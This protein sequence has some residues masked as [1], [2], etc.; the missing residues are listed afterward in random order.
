MNNTLKYNIWVI[1][2]TLWYTICF[3]APYF[4][5][6]PAEGLKGIAAVIVYICACGLGT[7]FLLYLIGINRYINA[8]LLPLLSF[9]GAT[10]SFYRIG[11][12][13]TLTPM[14]IDV[15]LH[16]NMEEAIGVTSW[17]VVVW[18]VVNILIACAFVIIRWKKITL[19]YSWLHALCALTLGLI[20]FFCN[21]RLQESLCQRFPYNIPYNIH[22]YV[23]LQQSYRANR[24]IPEFEM[25]EDNDSISIVLIIGEAARADHI[26]INGYERETT[27]RLKARKN[28]I[29]FPYIHCDQTHTLASLPYILTRADSANAD[30]QYSETSFISVFKEC[31]YHTSWISNQ[32]LGST[33][34]M[35]LNECDTSVFVNADKTVYVF[36]QWLDEEL[37][38][39]MAEVKDKGSD[40]SLIILH[41]IGSHWYYNNHVRED[42]KIFLPTTVNK[43]VTANS[44]E[45]FVNSY[46]N[47]I[48]YMDFFIDS[49]ISTLENR[50]SIIIYQS[51]HGEALGEDGYFLHANGSEFVKNPACFIWYSD[52]YAAT[53]PDKIKALIANKDKRYRTDYVFYSI[54]YAAG[55]EAEGD[56]ADVNIFR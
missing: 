27:P 17:Q 2:V 52:K 4:H 16:T 35:Y 37:I 7:Y 12:S 41:T 33:F 30:Y 21:D 39:V 25:L 32:D 56:N 46:D 15:I 14:L 50:N 51:D 47:T 9:L 36:S 20:C 45:Q 10:L 49:V 6:I 24:R 13:A 18:D 8:A 3:I 31:G 48:Y 54:L 22:E 43:V 40:K 26:Q 11:Y 42:M 34:S 44:T 28:I 5:D 53:H 1:A 38:P 55:I 29:S 19:T 23:S